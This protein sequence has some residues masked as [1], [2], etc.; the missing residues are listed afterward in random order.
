[1]LFPIAATTFIL[2]VVFLL[3]YLGQMLHTNLIDLSEVIYQSE[4]HRYSQCM[5]Y[6]VLIMIMRAQQ[7]FYVSAYGVMHCNLENF[8]GVSEYQ[9]GLQFFF[10]LAK[11]IRMAK[12]I[13]QCGE[14]VFRIKAS[15]K[16]NSL[17]RKKKT[18]EPICVFDF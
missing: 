15:S 5:K 4:W 7:P 13:L 8:V 6:S 14:S 17:R 9:L 18:G 11:P 10:C 12:Q 1:M 16:F 3:F 2:Q